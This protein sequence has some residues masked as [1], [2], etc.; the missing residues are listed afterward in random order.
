MRSVTMVRASSTQADELLYIVKRYNKSMNIVVR[1]KKAVRRVFQ[2]LYGR[3]FFD[4]LSYIACVC[5]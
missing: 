3:T 2:V 1:G 4:R 5:V